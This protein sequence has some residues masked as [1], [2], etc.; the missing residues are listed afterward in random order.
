LS[1]LCN[2][3]IAFVILA[4]RPWRPQQARR[5][6]VNPAKNARSELRTG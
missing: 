2:R 6:S 4:L 3:S 1:I 5:F